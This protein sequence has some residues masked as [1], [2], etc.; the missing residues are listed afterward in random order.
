MGHDLSMHFASTSVELDHVPPSLIMTGAAPAVWHDET[1]HLR[2]LGEALR[3]VIDVCEVRPV[4]ILLP[5]W[6]GVARPRAQ[7]LSTHL[8]IPCGEVLSEPGQA[9]GFRFES[10]RDRALERLEVKVFEEAVQTLEPT[11]EGWKVIGA[12]GT[13]LECQGVLLALGGLLGGGLTFRPPSEGRLSLGPRANLNTP[14][15]L[16]LGLGVDGTPIRDSSSL[17]GLPGHTWLRPTN[18]AAS[19]E[20]LG[21]QCNPDGFP[22]FRTHDDGASG[23]IPRAFRVAGECVAGVP[24]TW[25][26]SMRSGIRAGRSLCDELL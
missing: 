22:L 12:S 13:T 16:P 19:L 11:G 2:A 3:K 6:L 24:R 4:G 14:F 8:G 9:A 20:R 23:P 18:A 25:L 21:I 7:Q 5:P 1:S 10:A 26:A 17:H 15:G